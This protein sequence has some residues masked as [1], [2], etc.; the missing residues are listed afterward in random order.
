MEILLSRTYFKVGTNGKISHNGQ[1]VCYSIELPWRNNKRSISCI[2]EGKYLLVR[3]Y[4]PKHG[5]QLALS[6]VPN[7]EAILIHPANFALRELQGCIAPVTSCTGEGEG[8]Y[9][10]VALERLQDLI[11]PALEANEK[12]FLVITSVK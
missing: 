7:R 11:Y 1:F 3:R 8:N 10:R 12:V 6:I 5:H 4:H 9:S 2:P